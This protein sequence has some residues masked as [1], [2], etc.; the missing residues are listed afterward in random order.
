MLMACMRVQVGASEAHLEETSH[1]LVSA[2]N[3]RDAEL[4]RIAGTLQVV[5]ATPP[6]PHTITASAA[7]APPH[8]LP[9]CI[10][11]TFAP[12]CTSRTLLQC[13]RRPPPCCARNPRR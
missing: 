1:A 9:P 12:P 2:R 6:L 5:A 7:T 11:K 3:T 4:C 13:P 10:R 8:P